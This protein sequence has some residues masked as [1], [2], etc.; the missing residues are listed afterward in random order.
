MDEMIEQ[1]KM[2]RQISQQQQH[3][4]ANSELQQAFQRLR[5]QPRTPVS[6]VTQSRDAHDLNTS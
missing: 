2:Q 3:E 6:D 4:A 5:S 1:Q